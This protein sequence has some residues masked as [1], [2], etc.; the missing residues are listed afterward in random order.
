MY[1]NYRVV[2]N[3]GYYGI[4]EVFYDDDGRVDG[5]IAPEDMEGPFGETVEELKD[6]LRLMSLAFEQPVFV[7]DPPEE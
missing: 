3:N 1:W 2:K 4:V 6:G 5:W 7:L